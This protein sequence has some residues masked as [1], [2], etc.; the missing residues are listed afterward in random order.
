[1]TKVLSTLVFSLITHSIGC[2]LDWLRSF[3]KDGDTYRLRAK[4]PNTQFMNT[5]FKV[6]EN[7]CCLNIGFNKH[8]IRLRLIESLFEE[9]AMRIFRKIWNTKAWALVKMAPIL[10]TANILATILWEM[11]DEALGASIVINANRS[12][13]PLDKDLNSNDYF[14]VEVI[15]SHHTWNISAT[16]A[17]VYIVSKDS[18]LNDQGAQIIL[19]GPKDSRV[20]LT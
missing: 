5:W 19:D 7:D 14:D 17:S 2:V 9:R 1:M 3:V 8:S 12:L 18:S 16:A 10:Y 15:I 11:T 20:P 6:C 4:D 13:A